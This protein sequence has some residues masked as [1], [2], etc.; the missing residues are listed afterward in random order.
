M[1]GKLSILIVNWRSKDYLRRCLQTVRETAQ[2]LVGQIVVVDGGS[3]DGCGE[4]LATEFPEVEFVQSPDNVG[5]GRSNNLGF[6]RVNQPVLLLLNP[7]T[8]LKPGALARLLEVLES[9]PDVGI[10]SPRLLNTDGSLQKSSV[11]AFLTPLNQALRSEFLMKLWPKSRFWGAGEAYFATEPAPVE[12][13]S[14]ACMLMRTDL[15]RRLNGFRPEYFMYAEDMDLC[16]RAHRLGLRN[17]HVPAAEVIHHGGGSSRTQVS[18][19]STVMMR[20]ANETYMRLNHGRT[21]AALYRLLQ[22]VSAAV[23]LAFT[24]PGCILPGTAWQARARTSA[25]RW[26][27]VLKWAFGLRPS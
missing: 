6:A 18:Q 17:Y 22:A 8:E 20:V 19:F 4:M 16:L 27:Y 26:W 10:V 24:L 5:F 23:R 1:T 2:D 25:T 9:R 11:M 12:A 7:D 21:T 15:F 13:V 3:F 14:G